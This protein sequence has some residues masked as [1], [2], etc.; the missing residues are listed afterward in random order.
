MTYI[1]VSKEKKPSKIIF[2]KTNSHPKTLTMTDYKKYCDYCTSKGV[3]PPPY[4]SW[5]YCTYSAFSESKRLS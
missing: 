1:V 5:A 3:T 4:Y 2:G